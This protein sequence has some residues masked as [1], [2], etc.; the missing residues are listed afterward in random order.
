MTDQIPIPNEPEKSIFKVLFHSFVI[1]PFLVAASLV[2]IYSL[3]S[4]LTYED[5]T[6]YDYLNDITVQDQF[7]RP[8]NSNFNVGNKDLN[9][10]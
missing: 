2:F 6:P 9:D 4:L 7:L 8:K 3:F 5:A 10:K 1:I